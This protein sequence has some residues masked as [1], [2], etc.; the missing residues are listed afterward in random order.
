MTRGIRV[1]LHEALPA[2]KIFAASVAEVMTTRVLPMILEGMS[3]REPPFTSL[4]VEMHLPSVLAEVMDRI[5]YLT[6]SSACQ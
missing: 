2:K 4:T 1:M 5:I 6:L 3:G